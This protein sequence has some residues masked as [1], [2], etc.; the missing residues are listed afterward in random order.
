MT[1]SISI[2]LVGREQEYEANYVSFNGVISDKKILSI[3]EF[4]FGY[5]RDSLQLRSLPSVKGKYNEAIQEARW[6]DWTL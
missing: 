5:I 2:A 3:K 4:Y 6:D 1:L